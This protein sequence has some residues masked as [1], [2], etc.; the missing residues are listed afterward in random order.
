MIGIVRLCVPNMGRSRMNNVHTVCPADFVGLPAK[1]V[2]LTAFFLK[3]KAIFITAFVLAIG[4]PTWESVHELCL[5]L[6][7]LD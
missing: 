2:W 5:I 7:H 1:V 6:P 3:K 4:W